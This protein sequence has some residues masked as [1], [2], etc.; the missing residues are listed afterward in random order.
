VDVLFH[1]DEIKTAI[2]KQSIATSIEPD[3]LYGDGRAG[4]RIAEI[5]ATYQFERQKRLTY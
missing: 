5:L 4:I 2:K 3:L 1:K